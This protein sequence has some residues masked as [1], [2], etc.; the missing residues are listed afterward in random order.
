MKKTLIFILLVISMC[1]LMTACGCEHQYNE[2]ITKEASCTEA[3]VKTFTCTEC[4]K[5]YTEEIAMIEHTYTGEDTKEATCT[6][7][8][9]ITY[10][11]SACND[12]YSDEVEMVAHTFGEPTVTKKPTCME[13]G[14]GVTNCTV[15]G[16]VGTTET[17]QKI[18]C[19]YEAKTQSKKTCTNDGLI[20]HTCSMC[21]D[22]KEEVVK[23]TGHKWKAATC[24]AAKTCSNCGETEGKALNHNYED[25]TCTRCGDTAFSITVD[26]LP[27]VRSYRHT[28]TSHVYS[29]VEIQDCYY[30]VDESGTI[31][32][33]VGYEKTY[34]DNN[35]KAYPA[36]A[37]SVML[38]NSDRTFYSFTDGYVKVYKKYVYVGQYDS[39]TVTFTDIEPGEYIIAFGHYDI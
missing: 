24:Y 11:C 6:E 21:G 5:S 32:V 13:E 23:A 30:N 20:V 3:G 26:E 33:T 14:E 10:T 8:G 17:I 34:S 16:A 37:F 35:D 38:L 12:T 27:T 15:C 28:S 29:Q 19:N 39:V 1:V 2:E 7:K 22:K 4:N 9:V 36:V 18:E 31:T 25:G